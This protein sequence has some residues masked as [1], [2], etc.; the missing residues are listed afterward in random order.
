MKKVK[1]IFGLLIVL[2]VTVKIG[3]EILGY[4]TKPN[5]FTFKSKCEVVEKSIPVDGGEVK[6]YLSGKDNKEVVF[7]LHP[8]FSDHNA[9]IHQ[10]DYF[11]KD[12]KVITVDLVGH[13]K[14]Q[15]YSDKVKIDA[16]T[17]HIS[18]ILQKEGADQAH[19]V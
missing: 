19:F 4:M 2:A 16:S 7:F 10:L 3:L 9:F 8:A 17:D 18:Q 6:Y 15:K 1:M 13:G 14:S 11:S 12:Y 5:A